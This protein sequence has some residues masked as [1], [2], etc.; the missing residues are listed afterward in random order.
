M[1]DVGEDVAGGAVGAVGMMS[2]SLNV[3]CSFDIALGG[4]GRKTEDFARSIEFKAM[5]EPDSDGRM[6]IALGFVGCCG[7]IAADG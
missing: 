6:G 7:I 1:D 4:G 2:S 5:P 3:E